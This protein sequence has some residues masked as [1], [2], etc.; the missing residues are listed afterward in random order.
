M[1]LWSSIIANKTNVKQLP[2]GQCGC[3]K[4]VIKVIWS[5]QP[6]AIATFRSDGCKFWGVGGG[7]G[8]ATSG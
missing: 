3:A 7:G 5:Y 4:S 1:G 6:F 8:G 2:P